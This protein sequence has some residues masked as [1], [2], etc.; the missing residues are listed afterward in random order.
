M[1]ETEAASE[2]ATEKKR[3]AFAGLKAFANRKSLCI[4]GLGF[5]S[6]LPFMLVFD[7]LSA[8]LR[9]AGLSLEVIGFFSL[10]TLSYSFKFL[11]A[12]L[13]DR[14]AVP[15]L[16]RLLGHRRSWMLVCQALIM[17]GLW[18]VSTV[19]PT[20]N[21]G[22]MAAFAVFVGF[23]SATQDIVIDAW[24]IEVSEKDELGA[25]AAANAWG[26]RGSMIISGAV[27]L[28][29]ATAYNWNI[30]YAV[31]AA[32]MLVGVVSVIFAEREKEVR[33]RPIHAEGIAANPGLET[34]EWIIRGLL[35]VV[36]ALIL[37]SG[38]AGD[39]TVLSGLLG[40]I[41]QTATGEALVGAWKGQSYSVFVQVAGV[42]VGGALIVLAA[43]PAPGRVTRPGVYLGAALGD[44]LRDFFSRY[45]G[46]A[47]LILALICVYRVS[48]FVLNIMN[49]FYL[50]LGFSKVEIAEVR[51]VFGIVASM[52]G[53][54]LGGWMVGQ[55]GLMRTLIVGAFAGPLSN[56]VF[57][58]LA[59]QGHSMPALYV[60]ILFDNALGGISGTALIAYMS[61]LTA[62]GFTATQYALF[63][64]LYALPGKIIASQ[65]GRI[66]EAAA[67]SAEAGGL[68]AL[69][70]GMFRGLSPE[71]LTAG[72]KIGVG[73]AS[74]GAGYVTFF[75]YSAIIGVAGIVL[76]FI[77]YARQPKNP[78]PSTE[79]QTAEA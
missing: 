38:L 51:K 63:S 67:K 49:P 22:L 79:P 9:E 46:A 69:F 10:A 68:P 59:A 57:A 77:V 72:A 23:V 2:Q 40:A 24:R 58:W 39:A 47:G 54:A 45:A 33:L 44:P 32:M 28:L 18:A 20:T 26:Y 11:W 17:L 4:L 31:M 35:I 3:G 27:P 50:D 12:P 25:T 15:G 61:S 30:A 56:L 78:N 66:V 14:T 70:K 43:L 13:I 6:G 64:S 55:I 16:T 53:V 48:D 62:A 75:F 74:M 60:A 52:G 1:S 76:S 34:V 19:N 36:G 8:W 71:S 73:P 41:G 65:S 37:G 42:L 21:L 7:T 29:L 5:S